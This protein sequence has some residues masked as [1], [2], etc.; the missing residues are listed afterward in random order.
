MSSEK[1]P[2]SHPIDEQLSAFVDDELDPRELPMFTAQVARS[3]ELR[4]RLARYSLIGDCLRGDLRLDPAALRIADRVSAALD[5]EPVVE[6]PAATAG[7]AAPRAGNGWHR[8][9]LGLAAGLALAALLLV[10][11]PTGPDAPPEPVAATTAPA[12]T[13]PVTATATATAALPVTSPGPASR[14]A[15]LPA[16][17]RPASSPAQRPARADVR[18]T[19]YLVYHGEYAGM[20]SS[21]AVASRIVDQDSGTRWVRQAVLTDD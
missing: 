2:M 13:A 9:A 21:R 7:P 14:P 17:V 6:R 15:A 19:N 16:V 8:P 12:A 5:A 1:I 4:R 20:L 18:M 3:P 11:L 10:Q